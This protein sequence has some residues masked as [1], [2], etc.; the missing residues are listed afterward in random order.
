MIRLVIATKLKAFQHNNDKIVH[1]EKN[2]E[3]KTRKYLWASLLAK[4]VS[5]Q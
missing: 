2:V 5:T 4:L 1:R 3:N